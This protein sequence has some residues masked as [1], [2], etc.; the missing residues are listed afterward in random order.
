MKS[1]PRTKG[2]NQC[3]LPK[4]ILIILI[5]KEW[6]ETLW[7]HTNFYDGGVCVTRFRI[8][9][10]F[11]NDNFTLRSRNTF[12]FAR[13]RKALWK[14]SLSLQRGALSCSAELPFPS[15][16]VPLITHFLLHSSPISPKHLN[17]LSLA[18]FKCVIIERLSKSSP[19]TL[20]RLHGN[21]LTTD[22]KKK[23][24][25]FITCI[26]WNQNVCQSIN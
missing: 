15:S 18:V 7:S 11:F 17:T 14:V 9:S 26:G 19:F 2:E 20:W 10:F 4:V 3:L 5:F 25:N 13:R 24:I 6:I 23:Y 22:R 21:E 8:L 16:N 1:G 12:S